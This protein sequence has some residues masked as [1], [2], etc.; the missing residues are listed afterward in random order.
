MALEI[1]VSDTGPLISLEKLIDGYSWMKQLYSQV[2]IPEAVAE[3]L[4]QGIDS[5][6]DTYQ[7]RHGLADFV[8]VVE[9][10]GPEP[11]GCEALDRGEKQAIQLAVQRGLSLLIEEE[12]GRNVA[13]SLGLSFSGIAGQ[14]LKAYR[15]QIISAST[16]RTNL[17][18][19]L[20]AEGKGSGLL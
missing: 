15:M 8:T 18:E 12:Q 7:Q 16:A 6:W 4:C 9:V 2:L 14:I 1:V 11:L 13:N 19:L 17:A 5:S 3:E 10:T 20:A